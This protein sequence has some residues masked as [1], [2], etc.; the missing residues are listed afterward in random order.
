MIVAMPYRQGSLIDWDSA[1]V[2]VLYHLENNRIID[3]ELIQPHT[4]GEAL[5]EFLYRKQVNRVMLTKL[6]DDL[7]FNLAFYQIEP[8]IG[9]AG[10]TEELMGQFLEGAFEHDE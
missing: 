7:K 10:D 4:S 1:T 3:K 6:N 2:F 5:V 9:V 8:I